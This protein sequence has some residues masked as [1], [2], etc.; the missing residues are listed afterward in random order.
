[1]ASR[2]DQARSSAVAENEYR[3]QQCGAEFPTREEL[4]EHN[5][6]MHAG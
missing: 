3:C 2:R 1:M 6:R 5:Q 4:Q